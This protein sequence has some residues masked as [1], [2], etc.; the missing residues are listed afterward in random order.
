MKYVIDLFP[1]AWFCLLLW[2]MKPVRPFSSFNSE[3]L[4]LKTGN[5][6]RGF[7]AMAI[8]LNHVSKNTSGGILLRGFYNIGFLFVAVFFFYSG[9][10]LQKSYM[11]STGY[12][13]HFLARR[14]LPILVTYVIFNVMF[15][16][17][18]KA[19]GKNVSYR[20]YVKAFRKG[21]PVVLYSWY[22][23][24]ILLF[25][26]VF[27]MLMQL[28][29]AHYGM[30]IIGACIWYV[31][32]TFFCRK[33]N[34]GTWWYNSV[35]LLIVGM[36]WA[37]YEEKILAVIQKLYPLLTI[38]SW[39]LFAFS[40]WYVYIGPLS[41]R[42]LK[43]RVSVIFQVLCA[44]FFVL[45]VILILLKFTIGNP[46]L[47]FLGKIS[48]ELY[49]VQGLFIQYFMKDKLSGIQNEALLTLLVITGSIALG[50][51]LHYLQAG[52]LKRYKSRISK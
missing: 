46:V 49:L 48:L 9:Y 27:W 12:K 26:I 50:A 8:I 38:L 16:V 1:I 45:G 37:V 3:Y 25:Y 22:I 13:K 10:G 40:Y 2:G 20:N 36:F 43:Y 18:F 42:S 29:A 52:P 51:A 31:I 47:N 24:T 23:I 6:M 33:M 14:I 30:M 39:G 21:R 41:E 35:H 5:Y 28:C 15:C 44:L 7:L 17:L 32:Y 4:S 34:Y 11:T 19:T